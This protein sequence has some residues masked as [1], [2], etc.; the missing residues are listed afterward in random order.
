M[1]LLRYFYRDIDSLGQDISKIN[2]E[3]KIYP[4]IRFDDNANDIKKWFDFCY[5]INSEK[6]LL[7]LELNAFICINE[8]KDT[9][10]KDIYMSKSTHYVTIADNVKDLKSFITEIAH[11][12]YSVM[13][14]NINNQY[15]ER[16]KEPTL[17]DLYE[18]TYSKEDH[19]IWL[20]SLFIKTPCDRDLP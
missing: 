8:S 12:I 11:S 1:K 4:R 6:D 16:I 10:R 2:R 19:Y 17:K 18:H 13:V 14:Y 9:Q 7:S 3:M 15:G 20:S 5:K